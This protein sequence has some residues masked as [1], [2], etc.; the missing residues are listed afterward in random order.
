MKP[1]KRTPLNERFWKYVEKTDDE[2]GCWLWTGAMGRY[3]GAISVWTEKGWRT[4]NA[5][6]ASWLVHYGSIPEGMEVC[7]HCDNHPC[8]RPSHLF[9]GTHA[10]NMHDRDRKGRVVTPF[11]P[12][13]RKSPRGENHYTHLRPE[14]MWQHGEGNPMA[15]LTEDDVMMIRSLWE[16]GLYRNTD[17]AKMFGVVDSAIC[18]IIA[19]RRWTCVA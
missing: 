9:L 8:V 19:R 2:D 14:S 4:W 17:L 12:G 1:R 11:V 5:Q 10:D 3:Y 6:R 15:K 7:H 16:T 13:H 18:N